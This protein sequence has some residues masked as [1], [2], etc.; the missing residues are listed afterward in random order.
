M[1][2]ETIYF[3]FANCFTK[4][5]QNSKKKIAF[6]YKFSQT[7]NDCACHPLGLKVKKLQLEIQD[8]H[9]FLNPLIRNKGNS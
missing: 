6:S 2:L 9:F 1:F 5:M 8:G 3:N 7:I 4:R